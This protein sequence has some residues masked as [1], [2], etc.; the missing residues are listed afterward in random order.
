MRIEKRAFRNETSKSGITPLKQFLQSVEPSFAAIL[1]LLSSEVS[2]IVEPIESEH[3][4]QNWRFIPKPGVDRSEI[5]DQMRRQL[6]FRIVAHG[7]CA[8][9]I[10]IEARHVLG[11]DDCGIIRQTD[12]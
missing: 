5:G 6:S 1:R 9:A 4:E 10:L 3:A 12:R 11:Q 8:I 2:P 7:C